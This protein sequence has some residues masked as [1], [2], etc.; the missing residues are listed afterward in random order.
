M[1]EPIGPGFTA[2]VPVLAGEKE[3]PATARADVLVARTVRGWQSCVGHLHR[4]RDV[5]QLWLGLA[6]VGCVS[7]D[8]VSRKF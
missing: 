2:V 3:L 5:F 6:A 1:L 4:F 8:L 7:I